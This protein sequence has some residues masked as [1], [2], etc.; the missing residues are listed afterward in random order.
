[1]LATAAVVLCQ[2]AVKV[3]GRALDLGER[4]KQLPGN[5]HPMGCCENEH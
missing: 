5:S 2:Q 1:M 3:N 4:G